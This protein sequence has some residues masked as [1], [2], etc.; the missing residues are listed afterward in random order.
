MAESTPTA[1]QEASARDEPFEG[2]KPRKGDVLEVEFHGFDPK[3]RSTGRSGPYAVVARR[4]LP[5]ETARVEVRK[6]RG[7]R[8]DGDHVETRIPSPHAVEA[9]CVH[10]G[11]CGGCSFQ[12]LAYDRQLV[13]KHKGLVKILAGLPLAVPPEELVEDVIP[14]EEPFGY[15]NKMDFTFANRRWVEGHEPEGVERDRAL[16]LHVKGFHGKVLDVEACHI[17]FP[18]GNPIL[19]ATRRLAREHDLSL[20]DIQAHEG[21]LRHLVLRH[22]EATGEVLVQLVTSEEAPERIG[23]FVEALL[24]EVPG[25]TT[26]VQT[27]NEGLATVAQGDRHL[28]LHGPGFIRDRL[29][30][31]EFRISAPSFFQTNSAQARRMVE[32]VRGEVAG[33]GKEVLYDLYCGGGTFALTLARDVRQVI[34]IELCEPAVEDGRR[35]AR[36]NGIENVSFEAGDM[37]VLLR[38]EALDSAGRPPVD[39]CLVDPPRAGIHPKVRAGLLALSPPRVVWVSCNLSAA[40]PDLEIL[41]GEGWELRRVVPLDLFPHTPHVECVLTLERPRA[42]MSANAF[43]IEAEG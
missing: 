31:V 10:S 34:G 28:V 15:R 11:T 24:A 21:L 16:G 7:D 1:A 9:R 40:I 39:V 33:T 35:N 29:G 5:G 27:L 22:G 17:Q 14:C 2:R 43:R 20:W 3:G 36:E 37:A 12:D 42:R 30:D 6:R 23:P 8:V 26:V 4:G 19:Q 25:I 38:P 13:E 18:L 41:L 32:V